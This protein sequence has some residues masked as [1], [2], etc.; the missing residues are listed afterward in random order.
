MLLRHIPPATLVP[1][2]TT[3]ADRAL[4]VKLS[5]QVMK[6][7]QKV[8]ANE[9]ALYQELLDLLDLPPEEV[10]AIEA[11]VDRG[12]AVSEAAE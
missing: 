12:L 1:Q 6:A 10:Q 4:A 5:Y 7:D 8:T 3:A 9:S 2:L 11:E